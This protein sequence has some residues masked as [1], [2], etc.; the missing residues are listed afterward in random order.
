MYGLSLGGRCLA[1][2]SD[3]DHNLFLAATTSLRDDNEV[4]LIEVDSDNRVHRRRLFRHAREIWHVAPHP[5]DA[6]M[7][8]TC[9]SAAEGASLRTGATLWQYSSSDGNNNSLE[10]RCELPASSAQ[11]SA[12]DGALRTYVSLF[13]LSAFRPRPVPPP[14]RHFF[15]CPHRD[16]LCLWLLPQSCLGA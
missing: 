4:H 10:Q 8:F 11:D 9:H 6:S 16:T 15:F 14:P 13:V 5:S 1:P 7:F 3:A 2:V 12:A